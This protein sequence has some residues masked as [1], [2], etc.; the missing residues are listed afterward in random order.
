MIQV[1]PHQIG[2]K[3]GESGRIDWFRTGKFVE[4]ANSSWMEDKLHIKA[5]VEA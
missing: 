4:F 3:I 5:K 1:P 2:Q